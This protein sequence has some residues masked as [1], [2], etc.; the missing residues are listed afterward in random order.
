MFK[1]YWELVWYRS[2]SDLRSEASR[3]YLGI[4]WWVL[5]PAIYLGVFYF[6][7]EVG[8][9]RGGNNF[10]SFLLCGLVSWKW[11][12]SSVRSSAGSISTSVGLINQ[13]Y[14]PKIIFPAVV[15]V[16]NTIKF[17]IILVILLLLLAFVS[18]TFSRGWLWLPL[19][20]LVQF[21]LTL[22]AA[23]VVAA[24]VPFLP[25]LRYLVIYGMTMV[26]FMSGIFYHIETMSPRAQ[27]YLKL[28]PAVVLIYDYRAVL[29]HGQAPGL[30]GI[31]Y[32][33]GLGLILTV[34]SWW[35]LRRFDRSYPRVIG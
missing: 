6:V 4:V 24:V 7:F 28:N 3:A 22:G 27:A 15:V 16:T 12:D 25:D 35:L 14:I 33:L 20:V 9:R 19:L 17:L 10:V 26:F 18:H 32:V 8:L 1:Q 29:L 5:E 34:L 23:G 13:I 21:V 30:H 2:I 11:L 31:A